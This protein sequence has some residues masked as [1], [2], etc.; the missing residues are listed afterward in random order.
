MR[1]SPFA[2]PLTRKRRYVNTPRTWIPA[3]LVTAGMMN[4]LRDNLFEV[5]AGTAEM[6]KVTV[7]GRSSA[8][9]ASDLSVASKLKIGYDTTLDSLVVSKNGGTYSP[10]GGGSASDKVP[11]TIAANVLTI[12]ITADDWFVFTMNANITTTTIVGAPST[13]KAKSF[14][15]DVV[16][17]GTAYTWAWFTSTVK[18]PNNIVPSRTTTA[19]KM[20][21]YV[22]AVDDAGV[23]TGSVAGQV[24]L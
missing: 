6:Q 12:D 24:Y 9:L 14:V 18:W 1:F 8:A 7:V 11:L 5:E 2:E 21:R 17:N 3:E 15:L 4:T 22:F 16:G 13:G 10:I 19:G 23:V 20:D